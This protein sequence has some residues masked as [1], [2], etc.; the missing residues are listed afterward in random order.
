MLTMNEQILKSEVLLN[1]VSNELVTWAFVKLCSTYK[2][3]SL[4]V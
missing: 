1:L 2:Y 4:F 3:V